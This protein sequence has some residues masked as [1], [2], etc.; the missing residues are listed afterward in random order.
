MKPPLKRGEDNGNAKLTTSK[1][2]EI[3]QLWATKNYQRYELAAMFGVSRQTIWG[4][5]SGRLWHHLFLGKQGYSLRQ[6]EGHVAH[7]LTEN[8]V[9]DIRR[10]RLLNE[11]CLG[12]SKEFG[13]APSVI[14]EIGTGKAWRHI[15]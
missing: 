6:G 8:S 2:K 9:R 15:T 14:C 11:S 10:R 13:V 7:K 1:V 4:I 12:L 5:L 3:H